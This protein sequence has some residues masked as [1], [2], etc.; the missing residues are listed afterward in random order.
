MKAP[1]SAVLELLTG[2]EER[3]TDTWNPNSHLY[4]DAREKKSPGLDL[5]LLGFN[6]F[7][8]ELPKNSHVF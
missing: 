6:T 2:P 1:T 4:V 8:T 3:V 5:G 7:Y